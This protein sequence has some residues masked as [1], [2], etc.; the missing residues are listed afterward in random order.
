MN[1][2]RFALS[3]FDMVFSV[4][5]LKVIV[6]RLLQAVNNDNPYASL[7]DDEDAT[8]LIKECSAVLANEP[9][10][11]H[12][13]GEF[14]VVGDLHGNLNSLVR[15]FEKC[16]YPPESKYVF[17]GDYVDRGY[18]SVEV[19]L[20]LYS[21]K[22]LYPSEIYLLRGNH[23]SKRLTKFYGFRDD[24]KEKYTR[25]VYNE[26]I[27]SFN[28][29]SIA[30]ILN[31]K[32]FCVHGGACRIDRSE[33]LTSI[34]KPIQRVA[35]MGDI[36]SDV[37]WSDPRNDVDYLEDSE[38]GCG[39]LFGEVALDDFLETFGCECL[40]RAHECCQEGFDRPFGNNKCVTVFSSV[41]YQDGG[42]RGAVLIVRDTIER[43]E[44]FYPMTSAE[45]AKRRLVLP[46]W[47]LDVTT[48]ALMNIEGLLVEE[49]LD[50]AFVL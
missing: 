25:H 38:R 16:G 35:V 31:Q 11:L 50:V 28:N 14:H 22:L 21:L 18:E 2:R 42:N 8:D 10:V 1:T 40:I 27:K 12:L 32:I 7:P 48:N 9:V 45:M 4:H 6:E 13:T 39:Q 17:L 49:G 46:T 24:C 20:L 29:L 23:E 37:L 36:I 33:E 34:E 47:L 15:I 43:V 41:D 3:F 44:L 26:F 19:C 30:A 5:D